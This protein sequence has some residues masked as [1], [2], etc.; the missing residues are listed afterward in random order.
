MSETREE[1]F[2]FG[3]SGHAK[4]VL[5]ILEQD[6]SHRVAWLVDD[7]ADLKGEHFFGYQVIGGRKELGMASPCPQK[8]I[9]AIGNNGIRSKIAQELR[10]EGFSL[11]M[12][13]HPRATLGRGVRVGFGTVVMAGAVI[14]ADAVVGDDVIINTGATVDH[15]CQIGSG[16]HIAP[17]VTLCG[18]VSVGSGTFV[19]AGATVIQNISIGA[20][21]MIGAGATVVENV[22][23]GGLVVGA[24]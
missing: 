5:D 19:G 11:I 8:T 9:V 6:P 18:T 20:N 24:R 22:P 10:L 15:D 17:G 1:I 7:N 12:A 14:N 3:A 21:A 23:D 4:V 16:V 2:V 13:I